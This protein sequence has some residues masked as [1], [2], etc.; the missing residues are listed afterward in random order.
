MLQYIYEFYNRI[1]EHYASMTTFIFIIAMLHLIIPIVSFVV[2]RISEYR[3]YK[4]LMEFGVFTDEQARERA[5]EIWRPKS[6]TSKW[7]NKFI[8]KFTKSH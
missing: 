3:S 2:N 7:L 6:K 1:I 8:K 4:R 5:R